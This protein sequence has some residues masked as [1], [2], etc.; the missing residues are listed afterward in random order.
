MTTAVIVVLAIVA[1]ALAV[2]L[3]VLIAGVVTWMTVV[4]LSS[5]IQLRR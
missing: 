1:I 2:V 3:V 5:W 4:L